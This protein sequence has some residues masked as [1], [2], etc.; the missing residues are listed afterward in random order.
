MY[1]L[2]EE[3]RSW[4]RQVVKHR[5]LLGKYA[6]YKYLEVDVPRNTCVTCPGSFR[7]DE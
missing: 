4:P 1:K 5:R 6:F 2:F 3:N 7:K